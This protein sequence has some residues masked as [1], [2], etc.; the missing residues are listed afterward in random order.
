MQGQERRK[1]DQSTRDLAVTAMNKIDFHMDECAK[2][3]KTLQNWLIA[4]VGI[5]GLQLVGRLIDI[6][7]PKHTGF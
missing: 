6:V 1:E 4:L 5:G 7:V 3:Y 2:R